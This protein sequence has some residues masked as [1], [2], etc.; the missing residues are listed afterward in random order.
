MPGRSLGERA[1]AAVQHEAERLMDLYGAEHMDY[2]YEMARMK[3]KSVVHFHMAVVLAERAKRIETALAAATKHA[4]ASSSDTF[5]AKGMSYSIEAKETTPQADLADQK[6]PRTRTKWAFFAPNKAKQDESDSEETE[7]RGI[8]PSLTYSHFIAQQTLAREKKERERGEAEAKKK[9]V[10]Q[11]PNGLLAKDA[12]TDIDWEQM[13]EELAELIA[14]A[15][16]DSAGHVQPPAPFS[17]TKESSFNTHTA[18]ASTATTLERNASWNLLSSYLLKG[19][20]SAYPDPQSVSPTKKQA[21]I[22]PH[23]IQTRISTAES[24]DS[25]H[26]KNQYENKPNPTFPTTTTAEFETPPSETAGTSAAT[27]PHIISAADTINNL[28]PILTPRP[29]YAPSTIPKII[30]TNPGIPLSHP[31]TTATSTLRRSSSLSAISASRIMFSNPAAATLPPPKTPN[32]FFLQQPQQPQQTT[33]HFSH[34]QSFQPMALPTEQPSSYF[35]YTPPQHGSN[36][37]GT[38]THT[39]HL[40]PSFAMSG[41]N[42]SLSKSI[43]SSHQQHQPQHQQ[44]QIVEYEVVDIGFGSAAAKPT[45][46][47]GGGGGGPVNGTGKSH[48]KKKTSLVSN[49]RKGFW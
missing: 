18:P 32:T 29:S 3:Q 36:Q 24:D 42:D 21:F 38:S 10:S 39:H 15:A 27:T 43:Y 35:L 25:N 28:D 46:L 1:E 47:S 37:Q 31:A 7:S 19:M 41:R 16:I 45:G 26:S 22:I 9:L 6:A 48:L 14:N 13:Q 12:K 20:D 23:K 40:Y 17:A 4:A 44:Q 11:S 2:C 5:D 30:T 49:L 33:S 8:V 34:P